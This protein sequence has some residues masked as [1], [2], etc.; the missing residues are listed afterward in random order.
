MAVG[1]QAIV[2]LAGFVLAALMLPIGLIAAAP[3]A[4]ANAF[5]WVPWL[6][7][8]SIGPL[9]FIV[10]AQAP[11]M[12]RWFAMSGGGDPYPLYAASNLG[13]FAGLIAYPLLVEPLVPVAAQSLAGASLMAP[14]A[15]RRLVRAAAAQGRASRRSAARTAERA[16][17]ADAS[18]AGSCSPR[19]R[20]G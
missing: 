14:A 8:V 11:L 10:S 16:R 5:L 18:P 1:T 7:L 19:S 12:Q 17:L 6:L 20:R 13:S 3:P 9:F 2:H 15:A 4:D